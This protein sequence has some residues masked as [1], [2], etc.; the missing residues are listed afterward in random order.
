MLDRQGSIAY[1]NLVI[2]SG[3]ELLKLISTELMKYDD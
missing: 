3:E 1:S 2:K